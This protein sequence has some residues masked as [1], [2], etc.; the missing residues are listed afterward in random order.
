MGFKVFLET[1][2]YIVLFKADTNCIL[3]TIVFF[4]NIYISTKY[5]YKLLFFLFLCY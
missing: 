5:S 3:V 1:Y 4:I 2:I